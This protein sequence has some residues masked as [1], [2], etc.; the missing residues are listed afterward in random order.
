MT[1]VSGIM[2]TGRLTLGNHLGALR[3]FTD[4]GGFYFVADLHAMTMRHVP[5]R[6]AALTRETATLM[7]AAGS[8]PGTVFVQSDV[9][10]HAQLGYLL[11]CTSYV[12]ELSRMIQYKE[13]G[14]DR[15]MT[16][17][18]LFTYPCLMAA[19]ILLYGTDRVP[20]GDDQDQ[21]VELARDLAI[22]F[23]REYGETF[24]VPQVVKAALATRVRDLATPTA[25][26]SKSDADDA[27]GT[28]RLLDPPDVIR[29]QVMRA[30]TDSE[31]EV[32][33]DESAKPGV[34][35]LLE[36]LAA[37]TG[38][39]PVQ[40]ASGYSGYGALKSDVADAVLSV[41]EPL[42]REYAVL[43]SDPATVDELLAHGRDRAIEASAPRLRAAQ[44][45]MG[46]GVSR[47]RDLATA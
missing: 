32:R 44:S 10:A 22:R 27:V 47:D 40:L 34:T 29:R 13:K 9:P 3:R 15:P 30:V 7:L 42:Q 12:G 35:N 46:L 36:I 39:D 28:I 23:N 45:A 20:V 18:S 41:I 14:R 19:D 5:R 26:M 1:A 16:R 38:G 24:V 2:P 17:A 25:K 6:L 11:E 33:H 43:A 37:C 21:H 31:N 8:P 4:R